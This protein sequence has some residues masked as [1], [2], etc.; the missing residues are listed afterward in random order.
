MAHVGLGNPRW[1]GWWGLNRGGSGAVGLGRFSAVW[2][3]RLGA[4]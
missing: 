1:V 3:G 4:C 2:L